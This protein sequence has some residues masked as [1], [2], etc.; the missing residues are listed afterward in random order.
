MHIFYVG[1]G[2]PNLGPCAVQTVLDPP[3]HL[4]RSLMKPTFKN[5]GIFNSNPFTEAWTQSQLSAGHLW[6]SNLAD[7]NLNPLSSQ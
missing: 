6:M 3:N 2:D 7:S 5:S 1:S 4:L